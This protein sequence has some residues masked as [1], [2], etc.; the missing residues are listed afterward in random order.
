MKRFSDFRL[1]CLV[2]VAVLM[3]AALLTPTVRMERNVY[4]YLV[5]FDITQSQNAEDYVL[6]GKPVSRL[7][8]AKHA[9]RA[10][11]RDL[12]CGSSVG[13]GLFSAYDS[14][15]MAMIM[16]DEGGWSARMPREPSVLAPLFGPIEACRN[17]FAIDR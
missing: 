2:G 8:F 16:G 10:A 11:I 3:V 5:A 15:D 9:A 12:P 4:H 1:W 14:S 6:D 7:A 13:I 17:F